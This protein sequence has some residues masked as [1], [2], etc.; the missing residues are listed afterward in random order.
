MVTVTDLLYHFQIDSC[1][2]LSLSVFSLS[3]LLLNS[4]FDLKQVKEKKSHLRSSE[5]SS[6]GK[7]VQYMYNRDEIGLNMNYLKPD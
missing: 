4:V 3:A 7:K 5:I 1:G 6:S 2:L